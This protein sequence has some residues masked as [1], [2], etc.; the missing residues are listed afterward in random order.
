MKKAIIPPIT[1]TTPI[2]PPISHQLMPR[3]IS[4]VIAKDFMALAAISVTWTVK[5]DVPELVGVPET[6]PVDGSSD[7]PSGKVPQVTTQLRVPLPPEAANIA[8]QAE[9]T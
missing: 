4:I 6:T 2:V 8:A 3:R 1:A 5:S 9:P 7:N